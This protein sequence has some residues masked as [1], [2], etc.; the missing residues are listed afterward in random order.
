MPQS[1][2]LRLAVKDVVEALAKFVKKSSELKWVPEDG[3]LTLVSRSVIRRQWESLSI[4]GELVDKSQGF[5]AVGLL[6]PACEEFLWMKYLAS[7]PRPSAEMLV[8]SIGKKEILD[9]L[10][11]QDARAG[12]TVTKAL[13]LEPYLIQSEARARDQKR[14]LKQLGAEL[15]WEPKTIEGGRL[16][17]TA[18]VAKATGETKIYNFLYHASSRFVH[19]SAHELLRRT[20]RGSGSVTIDSGHFANYWDQ[21]VLYWGVDLMISSFSEASKLGEDSI[22]D[23]SLIDIEKLNSAAIQIGKHGPVPII[24]AEELDWED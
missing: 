7:I 23:E 2:E 16:P 21:F 24:T 15:K 12:R 3:M 14:I 8:K 20:W 6:R 9:S 4:V 13:G 22:D 5:A 17:S 10:R 1:E 19:F 18:F 11:A